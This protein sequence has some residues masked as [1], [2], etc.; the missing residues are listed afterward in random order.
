MELAIKSAA[1]KSLG[2]NLRSGARKGRSRASADLGSTKVKSEKGCYHQVTWDRSCWG[3]ESFPARCQ[4]FLGTKARFLP[5]CFCGFCPGA[6]RW[7]PATPAFPRERRTKLPVLHRPARG[8][9]SSGGWGAHL[10]A[11][12]WEGGGRPHLGGGAVP[13]RRCPAEG[14]VAPPRGRSGGARG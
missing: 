10:G 9:L 6:T 13:L 2:K 8:L 5:A 7:L 4:V 12:G 1:L 11:G 3:S 14:S